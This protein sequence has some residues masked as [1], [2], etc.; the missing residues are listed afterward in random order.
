MGGLKEDDVQLASDIF[1]RFDLNCSGVLT[2]DEL[3]T[4]LLEA[5]TADQAR[6]RKLR[7]SGLHAESM[8]V[9][10]FT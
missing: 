9:L 2:S 4:A 7:N 10:L 3:T 1:D 5:R 8:Y 6:A